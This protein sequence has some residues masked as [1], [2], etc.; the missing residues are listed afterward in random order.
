MLR[1][2][3]SAISSNWPFPNGSDGFLYRFCRNLNLGSGERLARTSDGVMLTV[4]ADD[5]I[6][7]HI[8]LSGSFD[9]ASVQVLIEHSREGDVIADIGANIGYV[10]ACLLSN[11]PESKAICFE[12]QP[13]V[14]TLL[15][16]NLAQFGDRAYIREIALSDHS[17][18]AVLHINN[19]NLGGSSLAGDGAGVEV[20]VKHAG[21]QLRSLDKLDLVKIDVEGHEQPI[22]EALEDELKRLQPRAILFEDH[23]GEGHP[24]GTIGRVL[25]RSGYIVFGLTR[26]W[27]ATRLISI[28]SK[29]DC[30]FND[31]LAVLR[32]TDGA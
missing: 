17:G 7:R 12:P 10:S 23:S 30:K 5:L 19:E 26:G 14:A 20:S 4:I 11:I 1:S 13:A 9:R 6:G 21:E 2:V 32:R 18:T 28:S 15:R 16:R 27:R 22:I 31:Y 25:A 24:E 29:E 3:L 8:L